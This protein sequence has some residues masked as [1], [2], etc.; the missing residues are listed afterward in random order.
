MGRLLARGVL[1]LGAIF[2]VSFFEPLVWALFGWPGLV[3]MLFLYGMTLFAYAATSK[4]SP[5]PL[6]EPRT[7]PPTNRI[8]NITLLVVL[9]AILVLPYAILSLVY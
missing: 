1:F 3:W 4:R 5:V 8:T 2:T 6:H 7:V 9:V